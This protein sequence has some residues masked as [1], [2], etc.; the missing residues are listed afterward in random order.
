MLK[1]RGSYVVKASGGVMCYVALLSLIGTCLSLLLFLGQPGD[2]LCRLQLPVIAIF[3]TVT[4]SIITAISI[5]VRVSISN[6]SVHFRV[7]LFPCDSPSL[8]M[9]I[10]LLSE[11]PLLASSYL[12]SVRGPGSGLLLLVCCVIQAGICGWFTQAGPSLTEHMAKMKIDFV[13]SF[14]ACPVEPLVGL[15][16]MQ[17]FVTAMALVSFMCTFMAAK[18][19][20]QYNLARDITFSSLIYCVIWVSF[21][22]V[23][24]SLSD[25][26]K[27]IVYV[28]FSLTSNFGLVAA[29]FF[30][31]CYLLLKKP[32]LDVPEYFANFLEGA[33]TTPVE[34]EKQT[35]T[36]TES[37]Q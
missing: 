24:I 31:K 21:I 2:L 30:P 27:C 29:Y 36:E 28:S 19:P 7:Q 25:K 1:H 33:P 13:R 12:N 20:H 6:A 3:Q 15:A 32:E 5:Q 37:K 34:E 18:P 11:F 4:L 8:S 26:F 17:G 9:Q 23:Y 35:E 22:P 16:L 10:F 14:L